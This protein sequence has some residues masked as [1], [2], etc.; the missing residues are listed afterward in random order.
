MN[1][2]EQLFER[3]AS[4]TEVIDA[5]SF[6][7]A[8]LGVFKAAARNYEL[9]H[10][11]PIGGP[12]ADLW[13]LIYLHYHAADDEAARSIRT[14]RR[15]TAP[16]FEREDADFV[17]TLEKANRGA[18]FFEPRWHVARD[19]GDHL[20]LRR[21][22]LTL[23][24]PRADVRG[25]SNAGAVVAVRFPNALRYASVGWYLAIGDAGFP[26]SGARPVV[27]LYF[28]V[29]DAE[30]AAALVRELTDLLNA[31][32]APF[33]LK[34][35]NDPARL[36]RRDCCVLYLEA[37]VWEALR[38]HLDAVRRRCRRWLRADAPRFA[39]PLGGGLSFAEEPTDANGTSFGQHRSQLAASGLFAAFEND[40][41]SADARHAWIVRSYR[42]AGL[43][44]ARPYLNPRAAAA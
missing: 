15:E 41:R 11:G 4:E 12:P 20:L 27:R 40:D 8:R 22:G 14:G 43:D 5:R 33:H 25:A 28:A 31:R 39:L 21:E 18:G 42:D 3:I 24:A 30:G 35:M 19:D 7:H 29:A 9:P 10:E 6:G 13:R 2:F 38:E 37:D 36:I 32:S 26:R 16:L 34:V 23:R 44:V 17:A 1:A